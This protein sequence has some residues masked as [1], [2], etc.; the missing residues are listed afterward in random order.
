MIDK[1]DW[2][3]IDLFHRMKAD[4][5]ANPSYHAYLKKALRFQRWY[6]GEVMLAPTGEFDDMEVNE[7]NAVARR[8]GSL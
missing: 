8:N 1:P 6:V 5:E 4:A 7:E 2:L 3:T